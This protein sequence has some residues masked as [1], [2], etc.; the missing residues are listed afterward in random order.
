MAC[1]V[2]Y[3]DRGGDMKTIVIWCIKCRKYMNSRVTSVGQFWI[4]VVCKCG[5]KY[6]VDKEGNI[7]SIIESD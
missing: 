3:G 4:T 7:D 2:S 5:I 6:R 1:F